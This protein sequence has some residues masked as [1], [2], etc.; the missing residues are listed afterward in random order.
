[1]YDVISRRHGLLFVR[2][3]STVLGAGARRPW[4]VDFVCRESEDSSSSDAIP[5]TIRA[6]AVLPDF[7][8]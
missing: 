4:N 1:M 3:V 6:F 7:E 8:E 5:H 2:Y